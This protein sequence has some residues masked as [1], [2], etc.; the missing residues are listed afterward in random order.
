MS[1]QGTRHGHDLSNKD[2]AQQ[3]RSRTR[4]AD[5]RTVEPEHTARIL[6]LERCHTRAKPGRVH[7]QVDTERPRWQLTCAKM[8]STS[9]LESAEGERRAQSLVSF[10]SCLP[11]MS[12]WPELKR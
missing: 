5:I 8:R 11:S 9:V 3:S 4:Y 12:I 10:A 6:E 7:W 1:A 2:I